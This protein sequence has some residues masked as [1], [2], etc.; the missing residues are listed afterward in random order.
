MDARLHRVATGRPDLI[1]FELPPEYR[2]EYAMLVKQAAEKGDFWAVTIEPW[3]K[4][5]STGKYS[6][7]HHF[8]G[9][10]QQIAAET[11]NDLA[12]VKLFVKRQAMKEGLPAK[13]RPD[14]S[15]VYSLTDGEPVPISEADMNTQQCYWC[16][17]V[18][19]LVA[20]EMGITLREGYDDGTPEA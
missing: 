19:H 16:I 5:R 3:R 8:N 2:T 11:G 15:I 13:T 18:C 12:D 6:Q 7:N 1:S 14:G 20:A 17:E 9:H 4:K 10:C